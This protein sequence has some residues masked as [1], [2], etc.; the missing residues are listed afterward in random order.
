M[1]KELALL[2]QR[3]SCP[4]TPRFLDLKAVGATCWAPAP[5]LV[6]AP[7]QSVAYTCL[8]KNEVLENCRQ[9]QWSEANVFSAA[10]LCG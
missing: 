5:L 7:K 6:H 10:A 3:S 2:Y 8:L 9:S 4:L 1:G